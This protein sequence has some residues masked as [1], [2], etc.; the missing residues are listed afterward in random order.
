MISNIY[1]STSDWLIATSTQG[2][3]PYI[4]PTQPMSGMVR[5]SGGQMQ[6]YDGTSWLSVN[7]GVATVDL[8]ARTKKVL[9]WAEHEMLL[10]AQY[11][12]LAKKNPAVEDALRAVEESKQ[13]LRVIAALVEEYQ[14]A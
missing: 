13:K 8:T 2:S 9:E 14:N 12:E 10:Q 7:G 6:V 3:M 5:V 11:Q 4:T 1:T